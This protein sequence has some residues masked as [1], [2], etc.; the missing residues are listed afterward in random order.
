MRDFPPIDVALLPIGDKFTMSIGEALRTALL[1]Q[2]NIVIPMHC[3]N[4]NS[5]DFK[6]KIEANS[7]I[8]VELLKMGENFQYL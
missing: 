5:E 6:S 2:P 1:M 3:H 7:D 4:S 8:K